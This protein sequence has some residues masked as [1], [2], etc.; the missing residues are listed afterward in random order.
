M[1]LFLTLSIIIT[2]TSCVQFKNWVKSKREVRIETNHELD[3]VISM[4]TVKI[5][6]IK[7]KPDSTL[8]KVTISDLI[9]KGSIT[10]DDRFFKTEIVYADS[11]IHLKVNLDSIPAIET[12]SEKSTTSISKKESKVAVIEDQSKTKEIKTFNWWP[13]AIGVIGLFL[14]VILLR[15]LGFDFKK[16]NSS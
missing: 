12:V 1:K 2:L 15:Y 6:E 3:S 13:V 16:R 11:T 9:K 4:E 10:F 8:M 7:T 14:L 5:R